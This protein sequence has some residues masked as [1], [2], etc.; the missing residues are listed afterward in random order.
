MSHSVDPQRHTMKFVFLPPHDEE[1]GHLSQR[2]AR[3]VPQFAVVLP[4]TAAEVEREI[5]DAQ[6]AFGELPRDLLALATRLRWLQ[7]PDAGPRPGYYYEEL[8]RHPVVVTNLRA[9]HSDH[10][11]VHAVAFVLAFARGLHRYLSDQA[12]RRWAPAPMNTGVIHLPTATA[13]I[14]GVGAIGTEIARL[15]AG[16]GMQVVGVDPRNAAT[17]TGV[18]SMHPPAELDQLLPAADF[19]I[20]TLPH[21]PVSER[22]MRADRFAR[23]KPSGILIN[24]GRGQTVDLADLEE[25]LRRGRLAGAGLDVFEIEPLPPDHPLWRAP[26]VLITPHVAGYGP[27]VAERRAEIVIENARRFVSGAPLCNVVDKANWF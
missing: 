1:T 9:V 5:V 26:N 13:L 17:P 12:A 16:F 8:V 24:V 20:M 21:T 27:F 3:E 6:A 10:V 25:A 18:R 2:L 23:M 4:A 11:A 15:C 22:L 7:A 14:L 19:V